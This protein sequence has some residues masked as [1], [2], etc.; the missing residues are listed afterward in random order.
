MKSKKNNFVRTDY[1]YFTELV[2]VA[3]EQHD[4]A[5]SYSSQNEL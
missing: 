2:I 1:V 3:G 4:W 5:C